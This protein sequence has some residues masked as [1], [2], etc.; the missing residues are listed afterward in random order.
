[1]SFQLTVN[2]VVRIFLL[3]LLFASATFR[4][5]AQAK[6]DSLSLLHSPKKATLFSAAL[7]GAGQFYNKKYWKIPVIYVGFTAL[8]YFVVTNN[9]D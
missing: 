4:S 8:G 5:E 1:M 6:Q 9:K 3:L 2:N 7:P